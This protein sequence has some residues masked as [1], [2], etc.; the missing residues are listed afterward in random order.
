MTRSLSPWLTAT[1]Q[2][3]KLFILYALTGLGVLTALAGMFPAVRHLLVEDRDLFLSLAPG[4][5]AVWFGWLAFA[6]RCPACGTRTGWWYVKHKGITEWFTAFV[7][8]EQCPGCGSDGQ[9]P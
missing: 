7:S 4:I 6:F 3:W 2:Q 9:T 5:G 8:A 1:G